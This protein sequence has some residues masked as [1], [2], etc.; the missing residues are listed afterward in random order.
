MRGAAR[1]RV[2][3]AE[4]LY[5][6]LLDELVVRSGAPCRADLR[7]RPE[8]YPVYEAVLAIEPGAYPDEEWRRAAAYLLPD[9]LLSERASASVV[10][11]VMVERYAS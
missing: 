1:A 5:S 9:C 6:S 2:G 4:P 7:F 8:E 10:R 3:R 11:T